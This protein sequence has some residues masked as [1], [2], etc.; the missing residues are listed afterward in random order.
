[1][2]FSVGRVEP[3]QFFRNHQGQ[4]PIAQEFQALVI[5]VF[6]V[7]AAMG[8]RVAQK[9]LVLEVIAKARCDIFMPRL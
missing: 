4:N 1:V 7:R 6:A 5:I 8:Q 2:P 3:E 9:H